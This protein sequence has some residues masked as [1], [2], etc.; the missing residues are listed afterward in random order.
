MRSYD[1]DKLKPQKCPIKMKVRLAKCDK[2]IKQNDS[3]YSPAFGEANI[4]DLF[5]AYKNLANSQ[6]DNFILKIDLYGVK[7]HTYTKNSS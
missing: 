2:A 1:L 7:Y 4:S 5:I 6:L 3:H